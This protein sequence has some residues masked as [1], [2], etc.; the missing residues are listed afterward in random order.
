MIRTPV[1][2]LFL[3]AGVAQAQT[4]EQ[5]KKDYPAHEQKIEAFYRTITL[6]AHALFINQPGDAPNSADIIYWGGDERVGFDATYLNDRVG[7]AY[8]FKGARDIGCASPEESFAIRSQRDG[9]LVVSALRRERSAATAAVDKMRN[10]LVF[11]FAPYSI[12]GT[13]ITDFL[14]DKAFR[15]DSIEEET[16]DSQKVI[17][18]NWH[19]AIPD[20]DRGGWFRFLPKGGW[21]LSEYQIDHRMNTASEASKTYGKMTYKAVEGYEFPVLQSVRMWSIQPG[22]EGKESSVSE[23]TITKFRHGVPDPDVFN[24][25]HYDLEPRVRKRFGP[26]FGLVVV[27][28]VASVAAVTFRLLVNRAKTKS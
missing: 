28:A 19:A 8:W 5:F 21:V 7:A 9:T 14:K 24:L 15:Y 1:L 27:L 22:N 18:V 20:A 25:S 13:R 10:R 12:Q 17:K 6:Y 26:Y 2:I 23:Y 16:I 11:P 4:V 3:G